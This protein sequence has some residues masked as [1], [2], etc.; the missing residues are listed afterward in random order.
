MFIHVQHLPRLVFTL[1]F[2][3]GAS[4]MALL[5]RTRKKLKT[6]ESATFVP[7]IQ[8]LCQNKQPKWLITLV[9]LLVNFLPR[10]WIWT[11]I[12]LSFRMK[13]VEISSILVSTQQLSEN[14][15]ISPIKALGF[16]TVCITDCA[17]TVCVLNSRALAIP[18]KL[19]ESTKPTHSVHLNSWSN[20]TIHVTWISFGNYMVLDMFIVMILIRYLF[21]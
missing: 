9:V 1:V 15:I 13:C 19:V 8:S 2:Q 6:T 11:W 20:I 16:R 18:T 21:F 12:P 10:I 7:I 5:I 3:I 4:Y 14:D 17:A